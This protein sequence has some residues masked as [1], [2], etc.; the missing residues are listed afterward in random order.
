MFEQWVLSLERVLLGVEWMQNASVKPY[1]GASVLVLVGFAAWL[2]H[3]ILQ[4]RYLSGYPNQPNPL[5]GLTTALTQRG[6]TVFV[7]PEEWVLFTLS[8][9]LIVLFPLGLLWAA[10][11][12]IRRQE[13]LQGDFHEKPRDN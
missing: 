1:V 3:Q 4:D 7:R 8:Y 2:T 13:R 12:Y 5:E 6:L 9:F 11:V 10:L